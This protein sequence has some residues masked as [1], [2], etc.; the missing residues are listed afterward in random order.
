MRLRKRLP[1]RFSSRGIGSLEE[2][3]Q[4]RGNQ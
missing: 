2:L 1:R 4:F 3:G